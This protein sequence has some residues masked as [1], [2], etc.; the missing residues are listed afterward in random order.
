MVSQ[1]FV[2][3]NPTGIHARPASMLVELCNTISDNIT[4]ITDNGTNVNPKSI[5]SV[6]MGGMVSGMKITVQ[7]NGDNEQ[8]SLKKIIDLLNSFTE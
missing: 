2:V 5:I 7:V 3:K 1:E 8:D 6:L 4:I